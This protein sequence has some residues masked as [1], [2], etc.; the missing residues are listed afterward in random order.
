MKRRLTTLLSI[1]FLT[2]GTGGALAWACG[3]GAEAG[4][5]ASFHQYKPPCDHGKGRG[6]DHEC[7]GNKGEEGD[8]KGG[9][10]GGGDKGGGQG[11]GDK[12]GGGQGGGDKGGHGQGGQ[13]GG[14]KG[15]H[16]QGGGD[17]GGGDKGG[18]GRH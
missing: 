16:G 8:Q 14:D 5:S 15:G 2:L 12:G 9:D 13:G 3:V 10:K 7:H 11:G 4:G 17:K 18:H 6:E 1:G